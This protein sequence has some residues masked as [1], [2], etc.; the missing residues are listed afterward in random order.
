MSEVKEMELF[1]FCKKGKTNYQP[2]YNKNSKNV[3]KFCLWSLD[4][5]FVCYGV[6]VR[7]S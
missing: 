4:T 2:K 6:S 3:W 7:N 5:Y 1:Y